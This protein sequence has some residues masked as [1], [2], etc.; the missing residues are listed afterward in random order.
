MVQES[1]QVFFSYSHKDEA[2]R[3]KLANHL[4]VLEKQGLIKSW[5]DR[6]ILAGT[7]WDHEI[8]EHLNQADIILLLIS[9]EFLASQ[10][11][12][13]IEVQRAVERH[14]AEE[15]CVIP[16]ILRP[17]DWTGTP[18]SAL[19]ALPKNARA[20]TIWSNRDL[21][22]VDIAKGIRE[23]AKALVAKRK[24]KLKQYE[25]TLIELAKQQPLLTTSARRKLQELQEQLGLKEEEVLSIHEQV[26]PRVFEER[27]QKKAI[28][29]SPTTRIAAHSIDKLNDL[30]PDSLVSAPFSMVERVLVVDDQ[31][32]NLD[33]VSSLLKDEGYHID[34]AN[35]GHQALAQVENHPPDL[36]V[37]DVMMPE[38]DG[39]EVVRRIRENKKL[40]FI[41]ILM[42]TAD[43]RPKA[44]LGLELGANDFVRKPVDFD[45]FKARVRSLLKLRQSI[46]ERDRLVLQ[47]Q[48]MKQSLPTSPQKK[49]RILVVDDIPDN[50]FLIQMILDDEGYEVDIAESGK[51]ALIKISQSPPDLLILDVMMPEIDG[52]EITRLIRQNTELYSMPILLMTAH[53]RSTVRSTMM[54]ALDEGADDFICKPVEFDELL[55]RVRLLLRLKHSADEREQLIRLERKLDY[56][57]SKREIERYLS[58]KKTKRN[59]SN[60]N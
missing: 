50:I 34:E 38:I 4:S 52:L 33:L 21:A 23:T 49:S 19:Q 7:E 13:E 48:G 42:V 5:H 29:K 40:P 35:N 28:D 45:E 32:E 60:S 27:F 2:L 22:F 58:Y 11:C 44:D 9:A 53:D 25:A 6:K 20:V 46:A 14:E 10:Y 55:S 36:I 39:Y 47:L 59:S 8:S 43:P 26:L 51:A 24:Q 37:L 41:P 56:E 17:V 15:A 3:D 54:T 12:Y 31:P 1:I 57:H 30:S 18:F 16:I